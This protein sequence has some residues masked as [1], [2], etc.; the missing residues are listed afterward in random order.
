M[1]TGHL[2]PVHN[3][4]GVFMRVEGTGAP[5]SLASVNVYERLKTAV[6]GRCT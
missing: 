6:A 3:I 2:A 4:L 5:S 1:H